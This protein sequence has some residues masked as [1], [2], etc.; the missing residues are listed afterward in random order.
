MHSRL[1]RQLAMRVRSG[2]IAET[3]SNPDHVRRSALFAGA[4]LFSR[5]YNDRGGKYVVVVVVR[6]PDSRGEGD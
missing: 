6:K 1:A 5:W 3:L 4:K 2:R